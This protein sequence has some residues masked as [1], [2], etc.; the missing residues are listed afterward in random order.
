MLQLTPFVKNDQKHPKP[1]C[2]EAR[3]GSCENVAYLEGRERGTEGEGEEK[4]R[5][6]YDPF[7]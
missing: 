4:Q 5:V 2:L 7:M 6:W 1:G 3:E